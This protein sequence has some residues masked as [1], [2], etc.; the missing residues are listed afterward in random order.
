MSK[1]FGTWAFLSRPLVVCTVFR[2]F[3]YDLVASGFAHLWLLFCSYVFFNTRLLSSGLCCQW[4]GKRGQRTV[5]RSL[6]RNFTPCLF[7]GQLA[8]DI[9]LNYNKLSSSVNKGVGYFFPLQK[10]SCASGKSPVCWR[11]TNRSSAVV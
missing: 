4:L 9:E 11:L 7:L 2:H 3:F 10:K 8:Y 5:V 6:M 1:M